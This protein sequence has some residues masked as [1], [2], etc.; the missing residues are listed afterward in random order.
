MLATNNN[1]FLASIFDLSTLVS[2][3]FS[4]LPVH[5]FLELKGKRHKS[6][7]GKPQ[8]QEGDQRLKPRARET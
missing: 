6:A 7:K 8:E 1:N 5:K 2:C 4:V 3:S